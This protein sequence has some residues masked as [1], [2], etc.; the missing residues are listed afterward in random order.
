MITLW[1][2]VGFAPDVF[3]S[4]VASRVIVLSWFHPLSLGIGSRL[5]MMI[6]LKDWTR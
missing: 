2:S 5:Q 1:I 4:V 3:S 6:S